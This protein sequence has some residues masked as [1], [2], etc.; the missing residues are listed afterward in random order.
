MFMD[1]AATLTKQHYVDYKD[2]QSS[3]RFQ[4]FQK[5]FSQS[6]IRSVSSKRAFETK[7]WDLLSRKVFFPNSL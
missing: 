6:I 2:E 3:F 5:S 7:T 4:T 1:I